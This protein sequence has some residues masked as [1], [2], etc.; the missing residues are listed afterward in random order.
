MSCVIGLF[1]TVAP[2]GTGKGESAIK[3]WAAR[4][5]SEIFFLLENSCPK[6]FQTFLEVIACKLMQKK[7]F[8]VVF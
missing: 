1:S 5:L 2:H 4:K 8:L 3:L 6:C 7:T